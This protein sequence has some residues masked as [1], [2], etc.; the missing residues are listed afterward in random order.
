MSD[1]YFG[2][3][4]F[5]EVLRKTSNLFFILFYFIFISHIFLQIFQELNAIFEFIIT[6]DISES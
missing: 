4:R 6:I 1:K 2:Y 5:Q 3:V